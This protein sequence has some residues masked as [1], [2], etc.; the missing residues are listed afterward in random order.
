[1]ERVS[2]KLGKVFTMLNFKKTLYI[3]LL[4]GVALDAMAAD[5]VATM[6][7]QITHQINS[8]ISLL[9][10]TAYVSGVGFA[11][12]GIMQFKTHKENPQQTPIS[13]PVVL[14]MVATGLLFLPSIISTAG[15]SLFGSNATSSAT[16]GG[17][18]DLSGL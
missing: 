1:M 18:K 7:Q 6:A 8:V 11:M 4:T 16:A 2:T 17:A 12:A 13:K 15:V 9:S 14:L 5:T 10:V 3:V